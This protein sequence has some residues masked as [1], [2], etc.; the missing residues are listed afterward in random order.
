MSGHFVCSFPS[1]VI[2]TSLEQKPILKLRSFLTLSPEISL[3]RFVLATFVF[4]HRHLRSSNVRASRG[5]L[6]YKQPD[7]FYTALADFLDDGSNAIFESDIIYDDD[8][9]IKVLREGWLSHQAALY[10]TKYLFFPCE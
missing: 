5:Y 3:P 1:K 10:R 2:Q 8:D 9:L 4:R 6:V 7:T